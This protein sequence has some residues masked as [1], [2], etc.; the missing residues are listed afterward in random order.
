MPARAALFYREDAAASVKREVYVMGHHEHRH[1]LPVY[2]LHERHHLHLLAVVEK[3]CRLVEK[4]D[5]RALRE[6]GGEQRPLAFAAGEGV[7]TAFR[8]LLDAG[9]RECSVHDETVFFGFAAE[10]GP[11][12]VT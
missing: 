2:P 7:E 4:E 6:R 12:R 5:V 8:K 3:A 1:S 9:A 10:H 11:P